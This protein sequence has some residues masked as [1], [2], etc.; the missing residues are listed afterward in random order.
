[1][2][3]DGRRLSALEISQVVHR[4]VARHLGN[5][6]VEEPYLPASFEIVLPALRQR[7]KVTVE[8]VRSA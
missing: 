6:A 3:D 8:E 7:F 4:A 5:A 1:V 2:P